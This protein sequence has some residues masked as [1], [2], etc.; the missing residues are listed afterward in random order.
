MRFIDDRGNT[1]ISS[2]KKD[3]ANELFRIS[4][5]NIYAEDTL[6]WCK[7]CAV[8]I[9]EQYGFLF[10]FTDEVSFIDEMIFYKLIREVN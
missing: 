8:R 10:E 9:H 4:W 1:Y 3:L 6:D 7:Q 5:A 2:T